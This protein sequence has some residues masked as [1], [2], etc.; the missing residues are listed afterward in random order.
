MTI[1]TPI[2]IKNAAAAKVYFLGGN[3][4]FTLYSLK[5]KRYITYRIKVCKKDARFYFV[6]VRTHSGYR[7]VGAIKEFN[8]YTYFVP[9]KKGFSPNNF[10]FIVFKWV[11]GHVYNNSFPPGLLIYHNGTCC[12][13]G[14]MLTD[15]KSI[16][17]GIGP[18][19]AKYFNLGRNI[20]GV[21]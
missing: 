19:C 14:R 11:W 20:G 12:R 2:E 10:F 4:T 6:W 1:R 21:K 3:S 16:K 5:S 8:K 13:C 15:P 9:T 17:H 18:E 7:Y